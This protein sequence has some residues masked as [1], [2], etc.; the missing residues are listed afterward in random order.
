M[1]KVIGLTGTI[2]SGKGTLAEF[3]KGKGYSY[4]SLSDI[5]R[6]EATK[7]IA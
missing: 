5:L 7:R 6:E 1:R 4:F 3:L 2:A